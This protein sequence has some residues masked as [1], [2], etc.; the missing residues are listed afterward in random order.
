MRDLRPPEDKGRAEAAAMSAAYFA[1]VMPLSAWLRHLTIG[2]GYLTRQY[3]DAVAPTLACAGAWP[4]ML[5][6]RGLMRRLPA[7]DQGDG[8]GGRRRLTKELAAAL[9]VGYATLTATGGMLTLIAI[10]RSLAGRRVGPAYAYV[11][12]ASACVGAAILAGVRSFRRFR[13]IA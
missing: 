4:V 7:E 13:R 11:L 10:D 9:A 1:A 12:G 6:M 2:L 3:P 5:M 8:R